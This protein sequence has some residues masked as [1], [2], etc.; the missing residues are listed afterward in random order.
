MEW[1]MVDSSNLR[2]YRYSKATMELDIQFKNVAVYRY[3][4]VPQAIV[5]GLESAGSV[6]SYFAE[7]V[8]GTFNFE[9]L[10]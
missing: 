3:K 10:S 5:K 1:K 9:R 4:L 6:G 2:A 8:K 7:N